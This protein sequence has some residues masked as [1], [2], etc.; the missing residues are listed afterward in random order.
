ME[1]KDAFNYGLPTVLLSVLVWA[2][3]KMSLY[4][5]SKIVEPIVDSHLLLMKTLQDE[6]PKVVRKLEHVTMYAAKATKETHDQ[7]VGLKEAVSTQ[8][9][10]IKETIEEQ[11]NNLVREQN[12]S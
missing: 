10:V 9:T 6:L 2:I 4:I 8:T 3:Y 12:G 5:K 7:M 1:W 11:T